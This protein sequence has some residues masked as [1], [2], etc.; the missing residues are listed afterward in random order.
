[1]K[2]TLSIIL[3]LSLC[4]SFSACVKSEPKEISCEEIIA[5]YKD[6]GYT[7][8]Y[9]GHENDESYHDLGMYCCFE[10]RDPDNEDNY[11][12]V[13]RYFNEEDAEATCKERQF[14]PILWLFFGIF[15]EWRWL[16]VKCYGDIE[17]E[18]FDYRMMKPLEELT[19]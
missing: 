12:Y 11:M 4:F 16:H 5:A 10:I 18:T 9:H 13:N 1:M 17:Y 7:V 15:G 19:K 6:A 2:K 3:L 8:L 14:N